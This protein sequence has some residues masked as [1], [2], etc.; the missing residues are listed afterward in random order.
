MAEKLRNMAVFLG[1]VIFSAASVLFCVRPPES[2]LLQAAAYA[3]YS[4]AAC[5]L[6][7]LVWLL[8]RF[9]R[10][11]GWRETLLKPVRRTR[12]TSRIYDDFTFR[13]LML[14]RASMLANFLF[15]LAKGAA[16]WYFSSEWL[17]VLAA[18][19]MALCAAKGMVL[20]STGK[21]VFGETMKEKMAR[22]W[23]IYRLCGIF[24]ILMPLTLQAMIILI[25]EQGRSVTYQG[26]L[27]FAVALYDFYCLISSVIYM[28][29]TRR[30]HTPAVASIKTVSFAASLVSMLTL[31][32]AMFAS[33]GNRMELE[34][35]QLM[36][37]MTGIAVCVILIVW[38]SRM[39]Y[40]SQ[41]ELKKIR[42]EM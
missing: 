14:G 25:V 12:F 15:A 40:R 31:Q 41:K 11:D 2:L 39:V 38:G 8:V 4:L 17:C 34:K 6:A 18:Y 27:I 29:K 33:F 30:N 32:T 35:Q 9:F 37:I 21:N 26:T 3:V 7:A 5:F 36:N 10:K 24:L 23:S 16:G 1:A 42:E 22:E 19:H 20:K 13:T 28:V